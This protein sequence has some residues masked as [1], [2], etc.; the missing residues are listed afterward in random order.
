MP[1]DKL[2]WT[3]VIGIKFKGGTVIIIGT[4]GETV[5]PTSEHWMNNHF[6]TEHKNY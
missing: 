5:E 1:Q 2:E 6:V 3:D 4:I